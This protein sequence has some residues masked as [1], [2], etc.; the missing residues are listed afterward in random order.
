MLLVASMRY[1]FLSCLLWDSGMLLGYVKLE[2]AGSKVNTA[3]GVAW[4]QE[5]VSTME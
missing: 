5:T 4:T 2:L 3:L 1:L